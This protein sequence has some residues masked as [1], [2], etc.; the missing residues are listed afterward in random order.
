GGGEDP[1]LRRTADARRAELQRR[2]TEA[3]DRSA[4]LLEEA[5]ELNGAGATAEGAEQLEQLRAQKRD[6][7]RPPRET[8]SPRRKTPRRRDRRRPRLDTPVER[9][10]G[11]ARTAVPWALQP[12]IRTFLVLGIVGVPLLVALVAS[13]ILPSFLWFRELGQEDVFVRIQEVKLL[14]VVVVGGL[15]ASFLLGNAWL[16]IRH[17]PIPLSLRSIPV[18]IWGS[19]LIAAIL[20]WSSRGG[21]QAFLLWVHR[22]P[23]GLED[24]L[25]HRDIG[26]FVFSLP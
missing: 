19:S 8:P 22:Q 26:F 15:T 11:F 13:Q 24:P 5:K 4:K 23:F 3:L 16:A 12:R 21:W 14:L 18:V 20:G 7:A 2:T 9:P 25:H 17:A 6:G 10:A 1:V